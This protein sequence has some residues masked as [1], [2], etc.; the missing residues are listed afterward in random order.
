MSLL[1]EDDDVKVDRKSS[2][3]SLVIMT[4]S[5]TTK[6]LVPEESKPKPEALQPSER[7]AYFAALQ[8]WINEAQLWQNSAP[9]MPYL[10]FLQP[11]P[12]GAASL[13]DPTR[14][15]GSV[16]N[17]P[18]T[19]PAG[20]AANRNTPNSVGGKTPYTLFFCVLIYLLV[21]GPCV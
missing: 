4:M 20:G 16:P 18:W 12:F 14:R 5:D 6:G 11:D 2:P 1:P 13:S 7:E 8:K 19:T 17:F 10:F 9:C 15:A 21:A 3:S